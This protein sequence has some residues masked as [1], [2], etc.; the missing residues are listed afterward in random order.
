MVDLNLV[1]AFLIIGLLYLLLPTMTWIVL[2]GHNSLPVSLWCGG[3][4]LFGIA[5]ILVSVHNDNSVVSISMIG[6]IVLSSNIIRIQSLR[7][8][9]GYS[10]YTRTTLWIVLILFFSFLAMNYYIQDDYLQA[11]TNHIFGALLLAYLAL[12][13]WR[14]GRKENSRS[15]KWIAVVYALM[16][17]AMLFRFNAFLHNYAVGMNFLTQDPSA[18]W[19]AFAALI[20]S[21]VGHFSYVGLSLDRSIKRELEISTQLARDEERHRLSDQIALLDRQRC[22]GELSSSLGHELNQPLTAILTNAQVAKRGIES[23]RLD[24]SN[25][26]ALLDKV[27]LNS[28]RAGQIVNRI[29]GFIQPL[30]AQREPVDLCQVLADTSELA[31]DEAKCHQVKFIFLNHSNTVWVMGDAIQL[32]QI[33]LN[34]FRNAIEALMQADERRIYVSCL[35][36]SDRALLRIYDTGT[37]F[38]LE[39]I[40]QVGTPFYTTKSTGLGVGLSISRSIAEQHAGTLTF[41]NRSK[42]AGGGAMVELNL[43][44]LDIK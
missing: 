9:L 37:G 15:A 39:T 20:S 23:A 38:N 21:V 11:Q 7:L 6:L 19:I 43:P 8:E 34:V 4:L 44:V 3:G 17:A 31:A 18:Q 22:L 25:V 40:S 2:K 30:S 35:I 29:R 10:L 13:A 24:L 5:S 32:S 27:I 26:V 12:L 1:T 16:A 42:E 33:V 28:H 41:S 36:S 14:I